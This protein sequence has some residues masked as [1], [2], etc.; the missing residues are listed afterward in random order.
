MTTRETVE[1]YFSALRG[2]DDW[3]ALFADDVVFTT[4]GTPARTVSGREAFVT[5]T[6]GFYSMIRSLE[7]RDLLVDG[8]RACALTRYQLAPPNGPAFWSDVAEIFRVDGDRITRFDIYF[9]SAPY[10]M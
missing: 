6:K 3:Q 10:P 9:D 8:D 2:N 1:R 5:G 7:L 4:F